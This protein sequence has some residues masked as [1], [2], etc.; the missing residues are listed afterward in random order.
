MEDI[1]RFLDE[2]EDSIGTSLYVAPG[3][4]FQNTKSTGWGVRVFLGNS[5][6]C[7]RL[8]F[9]SK[10]S[11]DI[12][13]LLSVD[14]WDG[15]SHDPVAHINIDG[16]KSQIDLIIPKLSALILDPSSR[17]DENY[18]NEDTE[19][20]LDVT[21][22]GSHEI[23]AKS[24]EE[25]KF[26]VPETVSYRESLVNLKSLVVGLVKGIS[27]CLLIFGR[28][29]SGKTSQVEKTLTQMGL[30]DGDGYFQ[31]AG[32]ISSAVAYQTLYN[33]RTGIILFD[34]CD[35]ILADDDGR[36][37]IK[38]ATDTKKV[39]KL[40]YS[41]KFMGS[42]DPSKETVPE[43]ELGVTKFPRYFNFEGRIIFISN[44][45]LDQLDPDKS[46]R[47][48]VLRIDINPSDQD[49]LDFMES[50]LDKIE[51]ND[52]LEL[53]RAGRVESLNILKNSTRK[54]DISIRK[55]VRI[56]N[57]AASGMPNWKN[58]ALLYA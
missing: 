33:N 15:S 49:L 6:K 13:K 29:G 51:L 40:S 37:M 27:N 43:E 22:G 9:N 54:D 2:L 23:Y 14:I 20:R 53:D 3:E 38:A 28:A 41:K 57:F 10:N 52:G 44:L 11:S 42:F 50:I 39:R 5:L 55:L 31:I 46:I 36:A 58:L 8:N 1:R 24:P 48:R 4:S 17:I 26:Q 32:S 21:P 7:F 47:T 35:S 18:L 16:D 19:I 12:S 30:S 25:D 56:M 34:D 45:T